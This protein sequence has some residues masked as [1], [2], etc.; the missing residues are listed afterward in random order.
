MPVLVYRCASWAVCTLAMWPWI[1]MA[2]PFA[3]IDDEGFGAPI[4]ALSMDLPAGWTRHRQGDL[5]Q[6]LQRQ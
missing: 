6:T 4:A 5:E 3:V 1:A 2:D